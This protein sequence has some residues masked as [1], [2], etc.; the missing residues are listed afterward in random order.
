ME[1]SFVKEGRCSGGLG[2]LV[3]H[4][5]NACLTLEVR[6]SETK[7]IQAILLNRK[8]LRSVGSLLRLDSDEQLNSIF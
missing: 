3:V 8:P 7:D 5:A 2:R 1:L 4:A 6:K